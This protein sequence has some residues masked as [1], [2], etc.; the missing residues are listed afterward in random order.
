MDYNY[1]KNIT[2]EVFIE[3]EI[4]SFPLSCF[5]ILNQYNISFYSYSSLD[6]DLREFCKKFSEDAYSYK[7]KIFYND[8]MPNGRI[9]FSLMHELGHILLNHGDEHS[10]KMEQEANYFSSHL[11][12]PRMAIHYAECK[13]EA[14]V[15]RLFQVTS[16]A[17][18]YALNDY[19]KWYKWTVYHKMNDFDKALYAH[20]YNEVQEKFIYRIKRCIYCESEIYNSYD[21]IC[22][23]CKF[24]NASYQ[25]HEEKNYDFL[26]AEDHWLYGGI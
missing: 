20:F 21:D 15:S 24:P 19:K 5:D 7:N 3:C 8:N 13:N 23:H 22:Y 14:D 10:P 4:Q 6:N 17:A 16:E 25:Y 12:A 1:I 2:L 9:R 26:V 18:L 11:L